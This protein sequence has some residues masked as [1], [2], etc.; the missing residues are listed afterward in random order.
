MERAD[1]HDREDTLFVAMTAP[2]AVLTLLG[3]SLIAVRFPRHT[4]KADAFYDRLLELA[5]VQK[6]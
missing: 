5:Q 3:L 2:E 4:Q 6:P 1:D